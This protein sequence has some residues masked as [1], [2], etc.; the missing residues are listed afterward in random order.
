MST[1]NGSPYLREQL[2]SILNQSF[3]NWQLLIRDDGSKDNTVEIIKDYENQ[4]PGKIKQVFGDEGGGS[5]ISFMGM[6]QHVES[7]YC[8]FSDQDDFWEKNKIEISLNR[9][10]ELE[11]EDPMCL[12]FT[13]MEVVSD[14]L[15]TELGSF[16]GLQKLNPSWIKNS[17]NVLAQSIAAGW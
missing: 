6:L 5:S 9:L 4:H 16:L 12:V 7:P 2:D 17:N 15:K 3:K 1:Y 13:D 11:K 14:D 10:K 8:M